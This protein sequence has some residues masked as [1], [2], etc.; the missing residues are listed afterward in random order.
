MPASQASNETRLPRAVVRRSA[1]IAERYA[2]KAEPDPNPAAAAAPASPPAA[3]AATTADPP[4]A[5]PTVDP[6]H[7][8]PNYWKQ[9]FD[10]TSGI[11][12]REREQRQARETELNQRLTELQDQTRT[13]QASAPAADIDL[14][15][16]YTP[17]QIAAY[18]EEQCRVM[19][20]TAMKAASA[21][22]KE[23]IDAEVRPLREKATQDAVDETERIKNAFA[24]K[25]TELVPD[26]RVT[27]V[28]PRWLAWLDEEDE[29]GATRQQVLDIHSRNRNAAACAKMFKLFAK[30][31]AV[32][33][34]PVT[35][36]GSG[37]NPGSDATPPDAGAVEAA[38][39]PTAAEIK[40]FFK[41]SSTVRKGQ[42]GFVT[43]EERTKFE[44]RLKLKHPDR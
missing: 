13:L 4:P 40:D 24:D 43:D 34:P 9:R 1:A 15:A 37:A 8:D 18:G 19:A 25:L 32:P 36:S 14:T 17:E 30:V 23:L 38:T 33:K 26:W 44:A 11:L 41:R 2:P 21:K 7:S 31:I 27:D 10:V 39:P 29:N 42:F 35:P 22:A 28:D 6:R 5:A 3:P 16:F 20:Q 12:A